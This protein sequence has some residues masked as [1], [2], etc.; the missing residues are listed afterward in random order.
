MAKVTLTIEDLED[1]VKLTL[2]SDPSFDIGEDGE[3]TN[4]QNV[5]LIA[6]RAMRAIQ[7]TERE[8]RCVDCRDLYGQCSGC[9][10]KETIKE[11]GIDPLHP[12]GQCECAGEHECDWC[13][14]WDDRNEQDQSR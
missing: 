6:M 10:L 4:A 13:K 5:G 1:C 12:N 7:A 11:F 2:E 3:I 14:E 8:I 9:A